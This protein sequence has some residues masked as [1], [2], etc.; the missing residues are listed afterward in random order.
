MSL[1][2]SFGT[3]SMNNFDIGSLADLN[4]ASASSLPTLLNLPASVV[5]S[6]NQPLTAFPAAGSPIALNY[7]SGNNCWTVGDFTFGLSGGVDCSISIVPPGCPLVIQPGNTPFTYTQSFPTTVGTDLDAVTNSNNTANVPGPAANYAV[8]IEL[9]LTLAANVS[10]TVP[11]GATGIQA[12]TNDSTSNTYKVIFYKSVPGATTLKD[13][14][15]LAFQGFVLPLHPMTFNNLQPG[16]YLYHNFNATLNLGFGVSV[17]LNKVFVSGQSAAT[18]PGTPATTPVVNASAQLG[19]NLGAS[20]CF[21][22]AYTGTFETLMWKQ[23]D[24][25]GR[26]HLYRSKTVDPSFKI[27]LTAALIANPTLNFNAQP[28]SDL[29]GKALPGAVTSAAQ[30]AISKGVTDV[31]N[32]IASWLT[33]LQSAQTELEMTIDHLQSTYI[34]LD[35]VCDPSQPAFPTAWQSVIKG[36]FQAAMQQTNSGFTLQPGSGLEQFHDDKTSI[37]LTLFGK[38]TAAWTNASI[39]NYSIVYAG[40]NTFNLVENVGIEAITNINGSGAE[41]ELFFAA[42]ATENNGAITLS[43]PE[44]HVLLKA[45]KNPKFAAR[46]AQLLTATGTVSSTAPLLSLIQTSAQNAGACQ[47]VELVFAPSAYAAL[48]H[49][50]IHGNNVVNEV[51]DQTNYNQFALAAWA[52]EPGLVDVSSFSVNQKLDMTYGVWRNW[53]MVS[54]GRDPNSAT[55]FPDRT[56]AGAPQGN[57]KAWLDQRFNSPSTLSLIPYVLRVASGFMNLCEDVQE[58]STPALANVDDSWHDLCT[59]LASIIHN[60]VSADFLVPT[61]YAFTELVLANG[62]AVSTSGPTAGAANEP[63]ITVT[64]RYA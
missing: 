26:L 1:T 23:P 12:T 21:G 35:Y 8:G 5:A 41:I 47:T 52:L 7:Q 27:D 32:K 22:F 39:A 24:G 44:L 18:L 64:L 53:N 38:F 19:V 4:S 15:T 63:S 11:I 50:T 30:S 62:A 3:D 25:T 2:L 16:D 59:H 43:P 45:T 42:Q 60:N 48:A 28:V 31:N 17:G 37:C 61:A 29:I 34:L 40:N 9:D 49:S 10:A 54:I 36:D 6:L 46:I 20:F 13:A 14:L 58:L 51:A 55:D 56:Q 57:A 33:P